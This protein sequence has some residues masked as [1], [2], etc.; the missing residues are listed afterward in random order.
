MVV[1]G[2][3]QYFWLAF[4]FCQL[5]LPSVGTVIGELI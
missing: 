4:S 2:T 1:I 5:C 3:V